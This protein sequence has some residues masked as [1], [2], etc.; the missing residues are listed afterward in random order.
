MSEEPKK[1]AI[2]NLDPLTKVAVD[3]DK[4]RKDLDAAKAEIAKKDAQISQVIDANKRL[5]AELS[6]TPEKTPSNPPKQPGQAAL[7]AFN[8]R[9]RGK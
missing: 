6:K 1:D 3:V 9:I 7:N 2:N 4:L 8:N 5:V